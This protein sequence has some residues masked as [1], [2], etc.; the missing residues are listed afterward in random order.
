MMQT[1]GRINDRAE[2]LKQGLTI[3]Q[4]VIKHGAAFA[5]ALEVCEQF[6]ARKVAAGALITEQSTLDA[7]KNGGGI[8]RVSA[9]TK[10]DNEK[11][12]DGLT[13][14]QEREKENGFLSSRRQEEA[15]AEAEYEQTME[16]V[17]EKSDRLMAQLEDQRRECLQKLAEADARAIVLPDGRRVLVGDKPGVFIAEDT[18]KTLEGDDKAKAQSLQKPDS[19]TA[20]GQKAWKDRLTKID[21]AEKQVQ[22]ATDLASQDGNNL[23]PDKK[24]QNQAEA[25]KELAEATAIT[26]DIET[27][28]KQTEA[29]AGAVSTLSG[30]DALAALSLGTAPSGRTASFA[31]TLD[32]KDSR[33]TGLQDHFTGAS[34][35]SD[36]PSPPAPSA[37]SA[38]NTASAGTT[39]RP[40]I[41]LP[42]Q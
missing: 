28:N 30:T 29:D 5:G 8:T 35:P 10:M 15:R 3:M 16:E 38:G 41:S 42:N 7:L 31:A 13:P 36:T 1:P 9:V 37:A 24:E 27:K 40:Q 17:R 2:K 14:E 18:G 26:A 32:E 34:Q 39:L 19:E 25:Q 4:P 33:A 20:T 23:K 21:N 6:D 22:K 12:W 11:D